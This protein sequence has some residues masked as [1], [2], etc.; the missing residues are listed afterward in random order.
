MSTLRISEAAGSAQ[1][2]TVA[3]ATEI[4]WERLSPEDARYMRDDEAMFLRGVLTGKLAAFNPWLGDD[5]VR[6]VLDTLEALPTSIDGNRE[7]LCWLRGQRQW[8]D[9]NEQRQRAVTLIDFDRPANNALHVTWEWKLKPP[10]R[11]GNRADVMFVV[12]GVIEKPQEVNC[13]DGTGWA[14]L[15]CRRGPMRGRHRATM[16]RSRPFRSRPF[17]GW[18]ARRAVAI[19]HLRLEP[20]CP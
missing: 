18:H 13:G 20:R 14:K 12:N 9:Q 15:S 1:F 3:H 6:S 16:F 5:A 8:Y 17:P 2:P 19:G 10:P 11:K 4:G 7:L